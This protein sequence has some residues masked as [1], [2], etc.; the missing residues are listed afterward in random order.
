FYA[1]ESCGQ[2]TPC[3]EGCN[4]L[5][6]IVRS[7]ED[8]KGKSAD[9]DLVENVAGNIMGKT[10]CPLGDAV[11]MPAQSFVRKFRHEFEEHVRLKGCPLK[12][13]H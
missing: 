12:G 4:W 9:I 2:C 11:A 13:A 6:K 10:I 5:V 8:G 3:R 1:H 7:I